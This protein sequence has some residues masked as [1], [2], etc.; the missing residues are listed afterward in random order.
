M[1]ERYSDNDDVNQA[2]IAIIC[3]MVENPYEMPGTEPRVRPGRF[4]IADVIEKIRFRFGDQAAASV[5]IV[6]H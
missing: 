3:C 4:S 1:S 5:R 2:V 6:V